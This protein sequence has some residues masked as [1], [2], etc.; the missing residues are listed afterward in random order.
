MI[1]GSS[2]EAEWEKAARGTAGRKYPRGD[3]WDS[4][5]ANSGESNQGKTVAVGSYPGGASPYGAHDMA[6][7]VWERVA[8]WYD[9]NYYQSALRRNPK[10]PRTPVPSAFSAAGR[11]IS[12]RGVCALRTGSVAVRRTGPSAS[13]SVVPREFGFLISVF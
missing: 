6:G 7:N 1:R 2:T 12:D 8:D 10:G 5:R 11:E 3:Q 9:Q 4:S 13:V